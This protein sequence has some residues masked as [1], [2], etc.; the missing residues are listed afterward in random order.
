VGIHANLIDALSAARGEYLA[1]CEGDDYWTDPLK[2][3]KQ[4]AYLDRHPEAAVCFHP[5]RVVWEDGRKDTK[6]PAV[7]ARGKWSVETLSMMT[8]NQPTAPVPRRPPPYNDIAADLFPLDWYLPVL[9]APHGEIAMLPETMAVSR[10]H[11]QGV[12]HDW[13]ADRQKFWLT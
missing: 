5:V 10:R 12:W 11:S 7:S 2:L 8:S 13:V 6:S 3:A 4:V 9:H 1:M